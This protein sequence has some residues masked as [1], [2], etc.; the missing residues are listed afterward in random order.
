[1]T[2]LEFI[3]LLS[4]GAGATSI[5]SSQGSAEAHHGRRWERGSEGEN[6]LHGVRTLLTLFVGAHCGTQREGKGYRIGGGGIVH[7]LAL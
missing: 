6:S 7:S 1:M 5:L 4:T 2:G 3:I